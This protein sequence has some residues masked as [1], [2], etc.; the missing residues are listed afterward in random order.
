MASSPDIY[1]PAFVADLFDRCAGNYR[2]WA[3]VASFGFVS[4]WRRQCVA[5][6]PGQIALA[7]HK[8]AYPNTKTPEILD[9]MAGT[10]EV[11]PHL[12]RLYPKARI[13][14]IDISPEMHVHALA[15][16]HG[17][18]AHRI[19][20][21]AADAL[22]HD[23]PEHSADLIVATFGLKTLTPAGQEVLARQIAATLRPG[24]AFSLIEASDPAE[25]LLRPLYRFHLTR[26]LPMIER[27]FLRGAQDFSMLGTYTEQFGDCSHFAQCLRS[28]G[29][30]VSQRRH[31]FGCASSVAG[32][33]PLA[34][35]TPSP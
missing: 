31:F 10:G 33:K 2:R 5:R 4:I 24:G 35:Q 3:A 23:L 25:W 15:Q 6:L 9:L 30:F 11:W 18:Y 32:F 13:T 26:V 1:D 17:S 12:L 27:L 34:A 16:L 22:R 20:H 21:M 28:Q 8:G 7:R 14:A 29:L 19:R